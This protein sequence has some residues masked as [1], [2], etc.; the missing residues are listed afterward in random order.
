MDFATRIRTLAERAQVQT[1]HLQTEAATSTALVLPMFAAL[2]YDVFDP[3]EVVPEFCADVGIK[4][5]E[6]VDYALMRDGVPAV[7]CEV[8]CWNRNLDD[9]HAS[10][11]YR[12]FS[13]TP[14]RIGILTS[15]IVYRFF[16]DLEESNK[17]D[18]S[19]FFE[20]N[21]FDYRA[22]HLRELQRFAKAEFD[23]ECL[24]AA[25]SEMKYTSGVK[26]FLS[27]ELEKPSAEFVRFIAREVYPSIVTAKVAEQFAVIVKDAFAQMLAER[28]NQRLEAALK[29]ESDSA[30]AAAEVEDPLPAG[31]VFREG[32]IETTE[33]EVEAFRTVLAI[34]A[35]VVD[36][37]RVEMRDTK[38]YCGI[39]F[40]GN[41]RKPICRLHFNRAKKYLGL[42]DREKVETKHP[43]ECVREIYMHADALREIAAYYG[44]MTTGCLAPPSRPPT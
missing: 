5:G 38:S 10:Q 13:V 17:M 35:Q 34:V 31:V 42:F 22:N 2:G 41:N 23:P 14:A 19:P 18:S 33:E 3:T 28:V 16:T 26:R 24:I 29:R 39:L 9:S 30:P 44:S 36:P 15:G 25:A 4:K 12:Y 20:F 7:L 27:R 43:I 40:D 1:Q 21:L 6:K 11:L 8:K 32:D 37:G